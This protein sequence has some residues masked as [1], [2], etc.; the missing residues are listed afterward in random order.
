MKINLSRNESICGFFY[1]AFQTLFLPALLVNIN[2]L[3]SRKLTEAELNFAFFFLNFLAISWIFHNYLWESFRQVT[4]HPFLV[5][6]AV[7]LGAAAYF[8]LTDLWMQ[9]LYW[10][11]P[12][13]V[14]AN[15]ASITLMAKDNFFLMA[16]GTVVLV[17]VVEECLYRGLFFHNLYGKNR[18]AAYLVSMVAFALIHVTG[19]IGIYSPLQLLAAAS[20]YLPAGLCLAWAYQKSGTIFAPI[21]I[22]ALVNA[23]ALQQLTR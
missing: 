13:F 1:L 12:E 2:A 17:P 9:L 14:N 10:L 21:F 4:H 7:V 11:L 15:D 6:Q 5:L 20:Q 3:L 16:L 8:S 22:H 18:I 23:T 19:Y